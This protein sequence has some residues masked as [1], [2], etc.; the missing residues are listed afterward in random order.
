[1]LE[2]LTAEVL[3]TAGNYAKNNRLRRIT[4]V[5][6]R[7]TFR[8]DQELNEYAKGVVISEGGSTSSHFKMPNI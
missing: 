6:I 8:N 7:E 2:Y 3:E 1:M 5:H 4:P